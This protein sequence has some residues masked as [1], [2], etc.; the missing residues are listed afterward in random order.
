MCIFR[1]GNYVTLAKRY[2]TYVQ[3]SGKLVLLKEKIYQRPVVKKL[4]GAPLTRQSILLNIKA[5]SNAYNDAKRRSRPVFGLH[6]FSERGEQFRRLKS[7]GLQRLT[8]CLT[9]WPRCGYDRQHPDELPPTPAAGGWEGMQQLQKTCSD[10]G[11][12]FTLH[13]HYRDYHLHAPSYNTELALHEETVT[14]LA[15]I[16]S[17]AIRRLQ[18]GPTGVYQS[19]EQR[20]L[21]IYVPLA[22]AWADGKELSCLVRAWNQAGWRMGMNVFSTIHPD[23]PVVVAESVW[24]YS[25]HLLP[26][27]NQHRGPILTVANW[28]GQWQGLVGMLN[29]NE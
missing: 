2:R 21:H 24:Q 25:N 18:S 11:F 23:A 28:S 7:Q 12:L 22:Y 5:G 26:G 16:F 29:L 13:D 9:G 1:K 3:D 15:D 14:G 20:R 27:L 17:G 6:S 8:V 4:I 19:L 10:L